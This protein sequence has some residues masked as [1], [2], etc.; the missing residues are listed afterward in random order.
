MMSVAS[1]EAGEA[2]PGAKY[3]RLIAAAKAIPAAATIV[4]HPC[5]ESSLRGAADAAEAGIIK[6]ILVGPSAKIKAAA[7]KHNIDISG[8]ELIDTPH[9]EAA[10]AKAV[11][12]IHAAKGEMLM[13]G[14]L[15]TD[16]LMRSVAAKSG[17]R[18]PDRRISTVVWQGCP[19]YNS[20]GVV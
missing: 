13:K 2:R 1:M 20:T 16:E 6:P 10:A 4:V 17:G 8:F 3:D 19:A 11:E 15:H 5:D 12:L 18:G 9:S 14:S 7:L